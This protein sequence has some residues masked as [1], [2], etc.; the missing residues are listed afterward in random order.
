LNG[1]TIPDVTAEPAL[2][3]V[4]P[5]LTTPALI[6]SIQPPGASAAGADRGSDVVAASSDGACAIKLAQMHLIDSRF[7]K[8]TNRFSHSWS[9]EVSCL[10]WGLK[11]VDDFQAFSYFL[12]SNAFQNGIV[13]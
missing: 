13:N 1:P 6:I 10:L 2:A 7:V 3:T 4:E 8:S 9:F 5:T 11:Q 12:A